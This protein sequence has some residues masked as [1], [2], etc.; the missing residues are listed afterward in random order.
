MRVLVYSVMKSSGGETDHK[1][2]LFQPLL[3][4]SQVARAAARRGR[5][6]LYPLRVRPL[7]RNNR[8]V[9]A[10]SPCMLIG[11]VHRL[12]STIEVIP[13]LPPPLTGLPVGGAGGP[14]V[15]PLPA[16]QGGTGVVQAS[17]A[18]C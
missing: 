6:L 14:R 9:R 5:P 17:G 11:A 15:V 13:L 10:R 8:P 2:S 3:G 7:R 18:G 1:F 12:Q 4:Y 16:Q